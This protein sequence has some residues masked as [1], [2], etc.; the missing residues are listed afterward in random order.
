MT[1]IWIFYWDFYFL[2]VASVFWKYYENFVLLHFFKDK[3][4]SGVNI[5]A[6]CL[7]FLSQ[8]RGKKKKKKTHIFNRKQM[9]E[10]YH[11][12]YRDFSWKK[13][14]NQKQAKGL[15]L[16]LKKRLHVTAN[17][18]HHSVFPDGSFLDMLKRSTAFLSL[19]L[20]VK[21]LTESKI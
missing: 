10:F 2:A 5:H 1:F 4:I 8:H 3:L 6:T 16:L 15:V 18:A 11:L 20:N 19:S 7:P 9:C 14:K 21:V 17:D 13:K 12:Q